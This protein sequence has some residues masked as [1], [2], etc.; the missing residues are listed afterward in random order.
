MSVPRQIAVMTGGIDHNKAVALR[1]RIDGLAEG[2]AC[3][4]LILLGRIIDLRIETSMVG[5]FEVAANVLSPGAPVLDIMGEASL[6]GIE[7]EGGDALARLNQRH[8]N[9][10]GDGRFARSALFISHNDD[11][12]GPRNRR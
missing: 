11:T 12:C 2:L 7:I 10:H 5:N 3:C 1:Q 6:P 4:G 9:M 8:R